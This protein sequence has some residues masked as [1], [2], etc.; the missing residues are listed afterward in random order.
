MSFARP[1]LPDL[2]T[3]IRADLVSRL[4]LT[5][6]VLRRAVVRVFATVWA[7]AAHMLHGHLEYLSKQLFPS[8]S[9]WAFLVLQ[10]QLF[11]IDPNAATFA[12]GS[13]DLTGTDATVIPASTSIVRS[14]G[15]T[16]TTD[17]DGTIASGTV[18]ISITADDAGE[19]GNCDAGTTLTLESPISGADSD[20]TVSTG[21]LTGGDDGDSEAS[22]EAYRARVVA[23]MRTRPS[24]G[25]E[26]DYI[27][28]AKEIAGVTRVWVSPLELGIGTVL[29][30]FARDD[31]ASPIPDAGEVAAVQAHI[32]AVRPVCA[33]V[34]VAA[35][36]AAP[37]AITV[38][39][40]PDTVATRAAVE[41]ELAD[42]L[43]REAE[44]GGTT[45]LS[46]VQLAIGNADGVADFTL[47]VPAADVTHTASQLATL[48]TV[49]YV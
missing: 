26:S 22:P 18:T 46:K 49:T 28:W 37:L 13:V 33:D 5:S 34:T 47:T 9:D 24:G 25:I 2:V 36:V 17:A 6:A 3:R 48:G 19:A 14:D 10:G 44:P 20:G 45:L 31:D 39:I 41:A 8:T 35:P 15:V 23:R 7:G 38:S 27:E 11:G 32:D 43:L 40:T 4:E 29:I 30:R 12:I 42:M 21:G 16:Y 1:T